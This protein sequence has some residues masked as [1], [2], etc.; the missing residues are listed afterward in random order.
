M[1]ALIAGVFLFVY[2]GMMAGRIPG[3]A[4]DRT[5]I[6]LLGVIVLVLSGAMSLDA[7][8]ESVDV[9]TIALLFG[10]MVLSA[11][12]RLGG[13]YSSI[14]R[15]IAAA[16]A[17][18]PRFLLWVIL[19]SGALSA[20]LANDIICLAMAPVLM[21]A[22][23]RRRLRPLPFLLALACSSNIGSAATLIGNPQNMLIGQVLR[24]DFADY[25][26]RAIVPATVGL[27]L[28]WWIIVGLVRHDWQQETDMA[29]A[30]V[31]PF[32]AWQTGK[33]IVVLLAL[34]LV[35]L[36]D[37]MPREVAAL[38]AAGILLASRRLA[39]RQF[40]ALIDWNLLLLFIGLFIVNHALAESGLLTAAVEAVGSVG[41]D[42]GHGGWLFALTA[43]LS[44]LVSNVPA[45]MLLLNATDHPQA[46]LILALASTLAGNLI[47]VGSIANIIVVDQASRLGL[48]ISFR[49]H[50]RVGVPVTLATLS[51]SALWIWLLMALG[52]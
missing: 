10:L 26:L 48:K 38:A 31:P 39:S 44:N 3:L 35:F 13:F 19:A 25:L 16:E 1:T 18:P 50:L 34:V 11:Q 5:G 43:V 2:A 52:A 33:G 21:E 40:L 51:F 9:P 32:N 29:D 37:P 42:P 28:C 23:Q 36:L 45:V 4:I 47:L 15:R 27:F 8:W 17:T 46:G 7:A 30:E 22:C 14:T 20:L 41:V 6:V 24:L 12:F 49:D